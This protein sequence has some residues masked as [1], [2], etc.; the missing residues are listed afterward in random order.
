M[1][2]SGVQ[3]WKSDVP[4]W[5]E[6][7]PTFLLPGW[8]AAAEAAG[9]LLCG[10]RGLSP[11]QWLLLGPHDWAAFSAPVPQ[12]HERMVWLA[13]SWS[14]PAD[15]NLLVLLPRHDDLTDQRSGAD[16]WKVGSRD[17][18]RSW[19]II[20][21]PNAIPG[22]LARRKGNWSEKAWLWMWGSGCRGT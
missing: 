22:V 7:N 15:V 10:Q 21:G 20:W 12:T 19:I 17:G 8:V 13:E 3:V 6:L 4:P 2:H 14:P 16:V 11:G 5:L 9:G 18:R 1:G